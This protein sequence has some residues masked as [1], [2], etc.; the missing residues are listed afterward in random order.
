MQSVHT[1]FRT[2]LMIFMQHFAVLHARGGVSKMLQQ[3]KELQALC[4]QLFFDKC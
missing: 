3:K 2:F 1:D 4:L